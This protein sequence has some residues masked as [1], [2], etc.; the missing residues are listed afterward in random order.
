MVKTIRVSEEY[1]EWLTAHKEAD[2]TMEETLRRMTRGPDP[3]D[4]AGL[5]TEE[6]AERAK[7]AVANLR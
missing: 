1:Y 6:E 2:E 3:S 5:L 4:V 7:E